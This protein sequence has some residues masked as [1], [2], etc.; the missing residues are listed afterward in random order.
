MSDFQLAKIWLSEQLGMHKDALHV[1]VGL[2]LFLIA[3]ALLRRP[4]RDWRPLAVVLVAALAGEAWDL[5]ETWIAGQRLRWGLSW[6]DIWLT[7]LWPALLFALAR[8][9]RLLRP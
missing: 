3:S 4:L 7:M 8:W 2:A 1:C 6:H 9:T 5:I